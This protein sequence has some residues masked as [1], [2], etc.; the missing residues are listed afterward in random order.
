M[1]NHC[2]QEFKIILRSI[3]NTI[4]NHGITRGMI[5]F[6]QLNRVQRALIKFGVVL[7]VA[8]IL[9]KL[10]YPELTLLIHPSP[11]HQQ[12]LISLVHQHA[13]SNT[14]L[15]II[16]IAL[17]CSIPFAPNSV[18][19]I[20]TGVCFGP[21]IGFLINLCGNIIGNGFVAVMIRR[22][23]ISDQ[24]RQK[25]AFA[26]L[27]QQRFP[28]LG[29]TI[30]FIVPVIP[31]LLVNCAANG[32]QVSNQKYLLAVSLGT[33]PIAFLYALGGNAI[34]TMSFKGIAIVVGLFVFLCLF[35]LSLKRLRARLQ[36]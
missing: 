26:Y 20:F 11:N 29:L 27:T 32:L 9:I 18:V 28:T 25:Q 13:L 4:I 23:G 19:C 14:L 24:V 7:V 17:L 8:L 2:Q 35:Y 21:I 31:N 34:F 12:E 5:I 1:I 30:G 3:M 15:L 10:Y 6:M 22:S 16:T 36:N 33:L